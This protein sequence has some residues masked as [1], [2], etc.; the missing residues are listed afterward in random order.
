MV[1]FM[2]RLAVFFLVAGVIGGIVLGVVFPTITVS[3]S[4][5]KDSETS[6]NV[7]LFICSLLSSI[8]LFALLYSF[9]ELLEHAENIE[10]FLYR[11]E[12]K[13]L[14]DDQRTRQPAASKSSYAPHETHIDINEQQTRHPINEQS[15]Y[16]SIDA[17]RRLP[18]DSE[19]TKRFIRCKTCGE[20]NPYAEKYCINC[21]AKLN[22]RMF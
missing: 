6:F 11:L 8:L 3:Q 19:P 20:E 13:S 17:S 9:A 12:A 15:T 2:K 21:G 10:G 22:E 1:T 18:V 14:A 7:V 5:W 4:S 16:T